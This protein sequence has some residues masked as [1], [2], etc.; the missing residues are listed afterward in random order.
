MWQKYKNIDAPYKVWG[1]IFD[2]QS[3]NFQFGNTYSY[4]G[5]LVGALKIFFTGKGCKKG[6]KVTHVGEEKIS[7]ER[8]KEIAEEYLP[9][10][11]VEKYFVKPIKKEKKKKEKQEEEKKK[12]EDQLAKEKREKEEEKIE[13]KKAEDEEWF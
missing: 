5:T 4:N 11:M 10:G 7:L 6:C 8:Q 13:K 1:D 3:Q 12:E 2:W 9:P